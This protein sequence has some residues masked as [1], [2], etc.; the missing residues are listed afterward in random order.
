MKRAVLLAAVAGIA[1]LVLL[2]P[3]PAARAAD[4]AGWGTLKGQVVYGGDPPEPQKLD[5][6]K[7]QNHCL[8][9]GPILSEEWVVNKN[10]KGVRWVFVALAPA[11]RGDKLPVHPDLVAIKDKTVAID[12]PCCHFIPHC[13]ALREGQDLEAKNSSPIAHN[14]NW[15]GHPLA[16]PS[17]N[18]LVPAKQSI[19]IQGLKAYHI[20]VKVACNIHPWMSGYVRVYDH[21]YF[22]VT[23]E[24]GKFELKKVP[25]G[26]FRLQTWQEKI[27]YGPG[28][29]DGNPVTIKAGAD[30]DVGKITIQEGKQ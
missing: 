2:Q 13:V 19:L 7:D 4:P 16:G 8:S 21:P 6:N 23:D 1:G 12:Q 11:K 22:A 17:G 25:V 29:R 20:P 27:G 5:V 30:T 18:Q 14:V 9:K 28:G 24:D 10:N 3:D 15:A 26:E